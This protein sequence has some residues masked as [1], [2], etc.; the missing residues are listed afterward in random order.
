MGR[1]SHSQKFE[2]G[3]PMFEAKAEIHLPESVEQAKL[4]ARLEA[5]ERDLMVDI[6]LDGV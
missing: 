4:R 2:P 6:E 1:H 3:E 5:L